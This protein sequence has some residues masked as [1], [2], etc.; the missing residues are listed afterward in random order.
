MLIQVEGRNKFMG[1]VGQFRGSKSVRI[2]KVCKEDADG[3]RG[4]ERLVSGAGAGGGR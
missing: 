4:A 2:T 3:A 1:Q